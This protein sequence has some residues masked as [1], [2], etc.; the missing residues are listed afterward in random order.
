MC[1]PRVTRHTSI[2]YSSSCHTR[3]SMGASTFFSAAMI[4]AFRSA[5][6]YNL[7]NDSGRLSATFCLWNFPSK[8]PGVIGQTTVLHLSWYG[9]WMVEISCW[10]WSPCPRFSEKQPFSY[11]EPNKSYFF[12]PHKFSFEGTRLGA[13]GWGTALQTG[14][15]RVRFPMG[16]F[17]WQFF[18]LHYGPGVD[19]DSYRNE[20]Q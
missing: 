15:S 3:V 20:Y 18:R 2:R 6:I 11:L 1:E 9:F 12:S 5:R 4:R 13:V 7:Q 10:Y 16:F 19:S 17:H 14:R 8:C